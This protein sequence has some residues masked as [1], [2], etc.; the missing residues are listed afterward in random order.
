MR[1]IF[2]ALCAVVLLAMPAGVQG[3]GMDVHRWL[4]RRALTGLPG[5]LKPFFGAQIDFLSERAADPDLWRVAGLRTDI[6]DEDPNHFLDIDALDE[7]APFVNVPRTWEGLVARYGLDRATKAGRV[8]WRAEDMYKR[9]V[10]HFTD[11]GR[12]NAP[13]YAGDNARYIAAVLSH[14]LA[15]AHQPLHATGNY[16]GQLT[17]QNGIHSRFE[18]TLVLRNLSTLN[19]APVTI[20]PVGNIREFMFATIVE[21]QSLVGTVLAADRRAT[22]G[23]ELYDDGYYAALL[24]GTRP[25]LEKRLGDSASAIA[26]V[27]VQAWKEAGSPTLP[28]NTGTRTPARIRR[29]PAAPPK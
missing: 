22:A 10:G 13:Y 29:A 27:I 4:T 20:R 5:E 3:W 6:G 26:S 1:V 21:S 23:R 25:V 24:T 16:D 18:T 17:G 12:P 9:L 11:M 7:P 19:L 8:P 28:L 14:Y 15:D 2:A